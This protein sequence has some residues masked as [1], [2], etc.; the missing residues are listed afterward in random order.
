M[1]A[2]GGGSPPRDRT[3][4]GG[5]C[6]QGAELVQDPPRRLGR[7]RRCSTFCSL[8]ESVERTRARLHRVEDGSW[9]ARSRALTVRM[10]Q[11]AGGASGVTVRSR[12][13]WPRL[14]PAR[15]GRSGS[16]GPCPSR[17]PSRRADSE[18]LGRHGQHDPAATVHSRRAAR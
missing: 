1:R 10:Q 12:S 7:E 18:E 9:P 17:T 16:R 2:E 8:P 3:V 13:P 6:R 5:R 14:S 15:Y 11:L 4:A